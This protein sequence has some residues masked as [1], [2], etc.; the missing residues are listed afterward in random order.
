M[1]IKLTHLGERCVI[2]LAEIR[3]HCAGKY[4]S[5]K[6]TQEPTE[7]T[8]LIHAENAHAHVK[9][10]TVHTDFHDAGFQ[11]CTWAETT[12]VSACSF[13]QT[14]STVY[15]FFFLIIWR[16]VRG[17]LRVQT[18]SQSEIFIFNNKLRQML[19]WKKTPDVL[20]RKSSQIANSIN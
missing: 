6:N 4:N 9:N 2:E 12:V 5:A 16:K 8:S 11:V 13:R 17:V 18:H 10:S 3:L 1:S 7:K 14:K 19:I 20:T 15:L